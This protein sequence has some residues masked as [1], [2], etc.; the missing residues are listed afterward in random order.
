MN[1]LY[2]DVYGLWIEG[3]DPSVSGETKCF[4]STLQTCTWR[5]REGSLSHLPVRSTGFIPTLDRLTSTG[6]WPQP[7]LSDDPATLP[8][9]A[10]PSG[11]FAPL[12]EVVRLGVAGKPQKSAPDDLH[13]TIRFK[14]LWTKVLRELTAGGQALPDAIKDTIVTGLR[15]SPTNLNK[16]LSER[17][18]KEHLHV[19][20]REMY[21]KQRYLRLC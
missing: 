3:R 16:A 12:H 9:S 4:Q 1:R 17:W 20:E 21:A 2:N 7:V 8:C 19:E 18:R 10:N 15:L 6:F 14:Q 13:P 11:S 5:K